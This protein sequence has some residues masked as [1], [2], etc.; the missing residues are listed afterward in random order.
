MRRLLPIPTIKHIP[1]YIGAEPLCDKMDE[2]FSG[3]QQDIVDLQCLLDPFR[4]PANFL[5]AFASFLNANIKSTDPEITKRHQIFTAVS[6]NKMF[7][8]WL[9]IKNTIDYFCGGNSCKVLGEPDDGWFMLGSGERWEES[10][11]ETWACLG[12]DITSAEAD[13][14][15][16]ALDSP[17]SQIWVKGVYNIDVDADLTTAQQEVLRDK[18]FNIVPLGMTIKIGHFVD[19]EF[20]IYF[21]LGGI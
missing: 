14:Y 12:L 7:G 21:V 10:I 9:Q 15:G 17:S 3:I 8:T 1:P 4:C 6:D 5:D 20:E 11:K 13:T 19:S 2:I 18:L 16:I